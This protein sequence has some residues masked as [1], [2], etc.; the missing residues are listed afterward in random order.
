[1]K[2]D[3]SRVRV[4]VAVGAAPNSMTDGGST[5]CGGRYHRIQ[6]HHLSADSEEEGEHAGRG[7]RGICAVWLQERQ[8]WEPRNQPEST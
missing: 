8:V 3:S 1:M 5:E 7:D 6:K 2:V 4:R